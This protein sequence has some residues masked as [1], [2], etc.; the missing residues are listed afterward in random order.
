MVASS[1]VVFA[2]I[3]ESIP[4][5]ASSALKAYPVPFANQVYIQ[6]L[7]RPERVT[8]YTING[9]VVLSTIT[10]G[11]VPT[12]QL[13]D[14][15]YVVKVA[16][17]PPLRVFKGG[18][19]TGAAPVNPGPVTRRE[20]WGVQSDSTQATRG[21]VASLITIKPF[22]RDKV[23]FD[24]QAGL[25]KDESNIKF[26]GTGP[27]GATVQ[28]LI[29]NDDD[30]TVEVGWRDFATVNA[31]GQWSGRLRTPRRVPWLKA[32]FRVKGQ[33]DAEVEM[34][35]RFAIG[36]CIARFS[37]SDEFYIY[38]KQNS[39]AP[40]IIVENEE[41]LQVVEMPRGMF[42]DPQPPNTAEWTYVNNTTPGSAGLAAMANVYN[43]LFG[44]IKVSLALHSV[45]GTG[46]FHMLNDTDDRRW[47]EDERQIHELFTADGQ[48]PSC[49]VHF[50]SSATPKDATIAQVGPALFG[51]NPD[52]TEFRASNSVDGQ[53]IQYTLR[54]FYNPD[55]TK[56]CFITWQGVYDNLF[57]ELKKMEGH[58]TYGTYLTKNFA[59]EMNIVGS[60]VKGERRKNGKYND[61]NHASRIDKD[62]APRLGELLALDN[63][64]Q[65]GLLPEDY[66]YFHFTDV[67]WQPSNP[68]VVRISSRHGDLTTINLGRGR[69]KPPVSSGNDEKFN[70]DVRGFVINN[71]PA[72]YTTIVDSA[73]NPSTRG[74]IYIR[75]NDGSAFTAADVL[76]FDLNQW[77]EDRN[78]KDYDN[79]TAYGNF[80]QMWDPNVLA[81]AR[82]LSR[83]EP[84]PSVFENLFE[85]PKPDGGSPDSLMAPEIIA[86]S[87]AYWSSADGFILHGDGSLTV[88]VTTFST[89]QSLTAPVG[90]PRIAIEDG[91]YYQVR[92]VFDNPNATSKLFGVRVV[93]KNNDGYG[94]TV[95]KDWIYQDV[96]PG[97][98]ELLVTTVHPPVGDNQMQLYLRP[99]NQQSGEIILSDLSVT[100]EVVP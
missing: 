69:E 33:P 68:T 85:N 19:T 100:E 97:R 54:E 12:D 40:N 81:K 28:Q 59:S 7:T 80:P 79:K 76:V 14:G 49:Q 61:F 88:D 99:G 27:V 16:G 74:D 67:E 94:A 66:G 39:S 24:S 23:V 86:F 58:H 98:H 78:P 32:Y 82:P 64:H 6:G 96:P 36:H 57:E 77:P 65:L 56:F 72:F 10:E 11:S 70:A 43:E 13:P 73:G 53:Y 3:T 26:S 20:K 71:E 62:G 95:L 34:E 17:Y 2:Q 90:N 45:S 46:L 38:H 91:K 29:M 21:Q 48:V 89:L 1:S 92:M 25:G 4:A 84:D 55:S 37:Q 51:I 63:A 52:G 83:F 75:K 35:E 8:F 47:F 9:T 87:P 42:D 41:C 22:T 15:V 50:L 18:L 44:G 60:F 5:V 93:G 31:S 30:G